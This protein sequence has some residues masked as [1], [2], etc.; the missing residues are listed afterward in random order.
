MSYD[1]RSDLTV[2]DARNVI[3]SFDDLGSRRYGVIVN[4]DGSID[5]V[6]DALPD[7]TEYDQ[8]DEYDIIVIG[9]TDIGMIRTRP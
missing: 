7:Q 6:I 3:D 4:D 2:L 8:G 1:P 9:S 5:E